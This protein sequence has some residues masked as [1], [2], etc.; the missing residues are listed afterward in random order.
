MILVLSLAAV[1]GVAV[2]CWMCCASVSGLAL[3][4]S[5]PKWVSTALRGYVSCIILA[6]VAVS[7]WCLRGLFLGLMTQSMSRSRS[8]YC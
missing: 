3:S 6:A 4:I 2:F 7:R 1:V 8:V 5:I